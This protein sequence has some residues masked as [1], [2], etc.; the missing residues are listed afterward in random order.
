MSWLKEGVTIGGKL[1]TAVAAV[2]LA[3]GLWASAP[4]RAG[5]E[6][7]RFDIQQNPCQYL[8]KRDVN[9]PVNKKAED[10]LGDRGQRS[11]W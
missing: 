7:E 4:T 8:N 11:C 3:V 6:A 10:E 1:G 2:G 5:A 9:E